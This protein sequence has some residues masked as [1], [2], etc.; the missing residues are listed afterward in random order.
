LI[1]GRKLLLADDSVVIQR[2]VELTFSD[3]GM[4]VTAVGNGQQALEKLNETTPDI[5]LADVF[6]PRVG[7]Y[8]LCETIKQN[9]RF[10]KIPVIL[11][12]GSF[13]PFDE[14]E[15]RRVGADDVVTKP[16][17]SIRQL[18]NRVGALLGGKSAGAE[19]SKQEYSTLG[20]GRAPG[21][22]T[23]AGEPVAETSVK[24]FVEAPLM[25]GSGLPEAG[26]KTCQ[27]DIEEQTADT[28]KLRPVEAQTA[29]AEPP[30]GAQ[31]DTI[32]TWPAADVERQTVESLTDATRKEQPSFAARKMNDNS[33]QQITQ[34]E[35]ADEFDDALLDLGAF[36]SAGPAGT[37]EE[38]LLDIEDE[39]EELFGEVEA[40]SAADESQEWAMLPSITGKETAA[41]EPAE[42]RQAGSEAGRIALS[43]LSPEAIDA[44][45]RR[46]VEQLSE[47]VVREIAWEVVPEMAELLIKRRL[48]RRDS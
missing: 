12:V 28:L 8:A 33:S 5:V 39:T 37:A 21:P 19:V 1:A 22:A 23:A 15:A 43:E 3:E 44:I 48:E 16:F 35:T 17:Q 2:V 26:A 14:A 10:S 11:L 40:V 34:L 31:E 13:E 38:R 6:M 25:T 9:E 36:E 30:G 29:S 4:E 46:V 32:K 45:A 27:P 47:K 18:V 20:L 24:V 42:T 7:G 41:Q